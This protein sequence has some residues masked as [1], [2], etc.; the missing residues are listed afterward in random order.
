METCNKIKRRAVTLTS[1]SLPW[2]KGGKNDSHRANLKKQRLL[3]NQFLRCCQ[4][5]KRSLR[6]SCSRTDHIIR[7]LSLINW[8]C[9]DCLP[10][11]KSSGNILHAEAQLQDHEFSS[12]R[13]PKVHWERQIQNRPSRM[14]SQAKGLKSGG[15]IKYCTEQRAAGNNSLVTCS[16]LFQHLYII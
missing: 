16:R 13:T 5:Y 2:Q 15:W 9:P 6:S 10:Q 7:K 14:I 12:T 4:P 3:Q 11:K 8:W 1:S